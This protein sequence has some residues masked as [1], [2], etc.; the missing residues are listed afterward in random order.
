VGLRKQDSLSI[1]Q[2]LSKRCVFSEEN[3]A[4]SRPNGIQ[5][6][7]TP[8]PIDAN[9]PEGPLK[10]LSATIPLAIG[11]DPSVKNRRGR[12]PV[13]NLLKSRLDLGRAS[14]RV[15]LVLKH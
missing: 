11:A 14:L 12:W 8:K 3:G 13:M 6:S 10:N 15:N 7:V 5:L 9:F 2:F 4:V 1:T